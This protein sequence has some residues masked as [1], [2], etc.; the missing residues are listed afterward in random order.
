MPQR[1]HSYSPE[2]QAIL[3]KMP[4]WI[5]RW[6][7]TVIAAIFVGILVG[8]YFIKYPDL[9]EAPVTITTQNPPSDLAARYAGLLD[10]VCV[11][12]GQQVRQGQLLM[13]LSTPTDY[14]D[15]TDLE[16]HL[17]ASQSAAFSQMAA[18]E[19][20]DRKYTLGELQATFA[21]FQQKC[22][23]FRHYLST[24]NIAR[25]KQL[26]AEQ[27]AK[28]EQY[29]ARLEQQ[30]K[31]LRKDLQYEA[32]NQRRDSLLLHEAVIS[33]ADYQTTARNLISKQNAKAGFEATMTSTEL[34]IIQTKQQLIE[35]SLQQD[36][37]LAT[38]ER[39]LNQL[40]QQLLA[41]IAQWREQYV[42]TS[43]ADGRVSLASYWS[44][45]Q[46]VNVGD[47][48]ASVVPDGPTEVVGRMQVPSAGFGKVAAGQTVNVKL[49]GYPYMEF[50]VLKGTIRSIS[51]VPETIQTQQ[52][53]AIAYVAEVVFPAGLTTSYKRDLPMIQQ[54]DG[55]G[56]IITE[57]MRLI[58]R[59][60]QP[61]VSLF[62]NR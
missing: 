23:D 41:Q 32:A 22:M 39:D 42:V 54:M 45:H 47:V 60:F 6:G 34:N 37:E 56:E 11:A 13:L 40:R 36:N 3:G 52:G 59:F 58:S 38:Y 50:G 30:Y 18:A 5:V 7:V 24:D 15:V 61:I 43:P 12:N 27:I 51:A 4:S 8:C 53:N 55:T 9:V 16:Q 33:E 14:G 49:N 1:N 35:L 28:N 57:D 48:L 2:A 62:K 29:Y 21:Q 17:G 46:R 44:K 20:L 19:W 25:K 10:T 31:L 26:L